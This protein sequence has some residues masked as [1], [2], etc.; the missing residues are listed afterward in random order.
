[1][2]ADAQDLSKVDSAVS[3]FSTSPKDDKHVPA[4]KRTSSSAAG[5]MNINDLGMS[6]LALFAISPDLFQ[7]A[8]A[9]QRSGRIG[10]RSGADGHTEK[11]GVE[12]QIAKETQKLNW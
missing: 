9:T 2:A 4:K 11:D 12:I 3:G 1:M 7:T 6:T 5:V 8:I 10:R